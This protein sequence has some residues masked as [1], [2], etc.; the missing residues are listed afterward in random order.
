ML[1]LA[2]DDKATK[3]VKKNKGWTALVLD[4]SKSALGSS[5]SPGGRVS[6]SQAGAQ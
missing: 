1:K 4:Q 3:K 6:S 2:A 5:S